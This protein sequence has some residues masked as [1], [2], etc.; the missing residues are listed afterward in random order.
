[1]LDSDNLFKKIKKANL[2]SHRYNRLPLLRSR[3][4]GVHRSWLYRFAAA[5]VAFLNGETN[6]D[7]ILSQFTYVYS[8]INF[9]VFID[10]EL[11]DN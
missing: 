10:L 11:L 3:P 9:P 7:E 8:I 6:V 4:G 5:K 1:M 2:V